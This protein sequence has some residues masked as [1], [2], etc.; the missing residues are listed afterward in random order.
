[1]A[2]FEFS[3]AQTIGGQRA[4]AG[5]DGVLSPADDW[6]YHPLLWQYLRS[7][8]AVIWL[9]LSTT[10]FPHACHIHPLQSPAKRA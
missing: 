7:A 3:V 5:S 9:L 10:R 6:Q 8:G 1:M 2:S 4:P